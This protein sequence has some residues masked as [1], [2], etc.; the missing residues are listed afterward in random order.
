MQALIRIDTSNHLF[1]DAALARSVD[2]SLRNTVTPTQLEAGVNPDVIPP[3]ATATLDARFVPGQSVA[4]V[5]A[6]IQTVVGE[7]IL[8]EVFASFQRTRPTR[9]TRPCSTSS[10]GSWNRDV[11]VRRASSDTAERRPRD[12]VV[13]R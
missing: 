3:R 2:A 1:P 7:A 10:H 11:I 9:S 4:S 12:A 6:E 8:R 13:F 5:V